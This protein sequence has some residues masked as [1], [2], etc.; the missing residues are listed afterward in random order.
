[1]VSSPLPFALRYD[2][3]SDLSDTTTLS[4]RRDAMAFDSRFRLYAVLDWLAQAGGSPLPPL[5]GTLRAPQLELSGAKL[6][7][8]EI[9]L[10]DE[11]IE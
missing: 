7:S 11:G 8:V 1:M 9:T 4:L 2:G 6:E 5:D 3:A 10:D